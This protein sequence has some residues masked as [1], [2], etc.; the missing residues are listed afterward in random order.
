ME[1]KP[2]VTIARRKVESAAEKLLIDPLMRLA[3][4]EKKSGS[5]QINLDK[6]YEQRSLIKPPFSM[7]LM[8]RLTDLDPYLEGAVDAIARNVSACEMEVKWTGKGGEKKDE[9]TILETFFF[10]SN[11]PTNPMSLQEK[12]CICTVDY[13]TLGSWNLEIVQGGAALKDLIHAPAEFI[14]VRIGE[15][16]GKKDIV[17]YTMIKNEEEAKFA[18]YGDKDRDKE[19]NQILRAINKKPG[20]RV[21]GKPMT[22]SLVGT[23]F[24]NALRDE[25]NLDWFDQEALAD[26]LILVEESID[27]KIKDQ[28]TADYQNSGDG[29][30]AMYILDGVGKSVVEQIKREL[31]GKS[32]EAMESNHRQRVLSTLRTPPAKVAIYEDANRANTI[33]QDETFRIEVIKPIQDTFRVRFN[34]LIK[35]GFGFE[36]WDFVI[37]PYSLKD[38]KEEA[39]ILGTYL[40]HAIYTVNKALDELN[41]GPVPGGDRRVM[42]TPLGLVDLDTWEIAVADPTNNP[43]LAARLK[44][45]EAGEFIMKLVELRKELQKAKGHDGAGHDGAYPSASGGH[46]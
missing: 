38:R 11:D 41:M 25:R 45:R 12:L 22:L 29:T 14:R 16:E 33:T 8:A 26:L 27:K 36:N 31:E 28:I 9:R 4:T 43:D 23:V 37:R 5:K 7:Q 40:D 21:Y 18:L 2:G 46:E 6:T 17:G 20:H 24:M 30:Q 34:H 39:E 3:A 15:K 44:T 10:E 32:F 42:N 19:I 13:V 35:Y 1:R